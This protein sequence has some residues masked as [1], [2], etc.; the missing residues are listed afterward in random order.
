MQHRSCENEVKRSQH[1]DFKHNMIRKEIKVAG[2]NM[3]RV[4]ETGV[5]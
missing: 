3:E 4:R 5:L 2:K 1:T